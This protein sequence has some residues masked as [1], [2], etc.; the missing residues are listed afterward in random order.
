M[1]FVLVIALVCVLRVGLRTLIYNMSL[2]KLVLF[3]SVN[4]R[5]ERLWW[6]K[7]ESVYISWP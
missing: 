2:L 5:R 7:E 1:L 3:H 6:E 4:V